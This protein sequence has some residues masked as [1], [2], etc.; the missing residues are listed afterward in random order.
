MIGWFGAVLLWLAAFF[1]VGTIGFW[2][3]MVAFVCGLVALTENL[4]PGWAATVTAGWLWFIAATGLFNVLSFAREYPW[5]MCIIVA[6]YLGLGLFWGWAKWLAYAQK[7]HEPYNNKKREWLRDKGLTGTA[8]PDD[9]KEEW[10]NFVNNS[11]SRLGEVVKIPLALDN[12]ELIMNWGMFWPF[13][14]V[15]FIIKDPLWRFFNAAF[16]RLHDLYQF[17]A[18]K[19]YA[20]VKSEVL[21]KAEMKERQDKREAALQAEKDLAAAVEKQKKEKKSLPILPGDPNDPYN[22]VGSNYFSK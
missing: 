16:N 2:V 6:A 14:F 21:S 19:I 7:H 5:Y 4:K 11:Y 8:I 3:T 9:L 13:S 20:D 22:A 10:T 17:T 1:A 18:D 15:W 12:K